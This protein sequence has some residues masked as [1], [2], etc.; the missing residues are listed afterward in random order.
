MGIGSQVV[1]LF[2]C[3]KSPPNKVSFRKRA[4]SP[5][6]VDVKPEFST[7]KQ[8]DTLDP[9]TE[10]VLHVG[11]WPRFGSLLSFQISGEN[12]TYFCMVLLARET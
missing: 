8:V 3:Q 7:C 2:S 6:T 9:A 11:G 5:S 10:S 1:I 12:E 4:L